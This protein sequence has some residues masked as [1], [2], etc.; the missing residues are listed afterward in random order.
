VI[1]A[2]VFVN[3]AILAAGL[4]VA[5]SL[6]RMQR[7][8]PTAAGFWRLLHFLALTLTMAVAA[9]DAYSIVNIGFSPFAS[10][11]Y[12]S[13]V[14][15]GTAAML[16]CFPFWNRARIGRKRGKR[17]AAFWASAAAIPLAAAAAALALENLTV[18]MAFIAVSFIPF[19]ASVFYGLAL[20]RGDPTARPREA[21]LALSALGLT[22]TAEIGWIVFHPMEEGY[23]FVTL[24]LA[25]LF[26]SRST[27][28]DR[29]RAKP[30]GAKP[31]GAKSEGAKS[32]GAEPQGSADEIPDPL[33]REK[34][35]TGRELA[36]A[37][38]I[39]EGKSNKELAYELG[40]AENTVRNHIYNLY[41]K[42]GIQKRLDLVLLVRKY[43][44][45]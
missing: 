39:L 17:F 42:L 21:W 24:P 10:R 11:L 15:V 14:L 26:V 12:S 43:R 5:L 25:Y 6:F 28:R 19:F 31:E 36:M 38:G 45:P 1:H 29:E 2:L 7:L 35:L 34:G 16:F 44:T 3:L 23:F 13:L 9:L 22:A 37:R 33:A 32:E 40:I 8:R 18:L 41:R 4:G 30:E 27:W 20:I